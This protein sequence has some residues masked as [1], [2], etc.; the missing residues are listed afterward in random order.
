MATPSPKKRSERPVAGA[1]LRAGQIFE[2]AAEVV[3]A[4][5]TSALTYGI[6]SGLIGRAQVGCRVRVPVRGRLHVGV[7]WRVG[8]VD[9]MGC[10]VEKLRPLDDV[11]DDSP[12]LPTDLIA[13]LAFAARYYH[14]PLGS[15]LRLALPSALR[16]TEVQGD[17]APVRTRWLVGRVDG[18]PTELELVGG[19]PGRSNNITWERLNIVTVLEL[20]CDF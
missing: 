19:A 2:H 5:A 12:L 1:Q 8:A 16:H 20:V 6:P 13:C 11:L 17:A 15:A 14:S 9:E 10:P 3:V 18:V 7:I 4:T